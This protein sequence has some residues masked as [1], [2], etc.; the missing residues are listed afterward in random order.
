M[1]STGSNPATGSTST[2]D[3][4]LTCKKRKL[5]SIVWNE[6]EKVIID[7]QDYAICKHCKSKLK[8]DSKNETKNLHVHLD[9]C[10]KQRNV[11]I[12]QQFLVVERK[13]Y[14]KVKIGGFTF[15]QD[16]LREKLARAIILHEYPFSIVD[17]VGFR[18]FA[19][20]LQ[21]LFKM[22]SRNT[23]K[24]DI[25][26]IYEFEKE[27]MSSYLEKLETIMTITTDMW[28]SNQKKGYMAIT[29]HYIDESWLLQRH[30]VRL[31]ML[32]IQ[33]FNFYFILLSFN[34]ITYINNMFLYIV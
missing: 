2:T 22:V 5:T 23:I 9:R 32:F 27:K 11:D 21:P 12:K 24:D 26:E 1:P 16:I 33:L 14:G 8:A 29:V 25:M 31:D 15:D 28:T 10:I 6:F 3:G 20:S 18:D 4:S 34:D 17:H 30:I 7:G 19:S 13:G